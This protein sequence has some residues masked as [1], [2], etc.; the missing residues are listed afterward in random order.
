MEILLHLLLYGYVVPLAISVVCIDIFI[1]SS[2]DFEEIQSLLSRRYVCYIPIYNIILSISVIKH[3]IN[4][5]T[6]SNDNVE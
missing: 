3:I 2:N 6:N 4:R 1:Q 5:L